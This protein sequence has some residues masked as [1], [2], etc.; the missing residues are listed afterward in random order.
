M[1]EAAAATQDLARDL[2]DILQAID[3]KASVDTLLPRFPRLSADDFGKALAALVDRKLICEAGGDAAGLGEAS[4]PSNLRSP[5]TLLKAQELR[6]KIR[7]K[8][9]NELQPKGNQTER[10]A[11]EAAERLRAEIEAEVRQ[12][13]EAEARRVAE[14]QARKKAAEQARKD[15]EE[16]IRQEATEKIRQEMA[17]RAQKE[18][19]ARVRQ[20]AEERARQEAE[21]RIRQEA[22]ERARQEAQQ[23]ARQEAEERARQEAAEQ[24]RQQAAERARQEAEVAARR[25]AEEQARRHAEEEAGREA[26]ARTRYEAEVRARQAEEERVWRETEDKMRREAAEASARL[27]KGKAASKEYKAGLGVMA[28]WGKMIALGVIALL[29]AGLAA[30]HLVSFDGKIPPLEKA[31]AAQFQ[32]PVKIASLRLSLL[33]KPMLR[34]EGVAIGGEGQIKIP[35][36]NAIG[37]VGNLFGQAKSFTALELDSPVASEEALGWILFGKPQ[38]ADIVFGQVRVIGGTLATKHLTLS[39]FDATIRPGGDAGWSTMAIESQD[40]NMVIELT[41]KGDSVQIEFKAKTFK[42]PFGSTLGLDEVVASGTA[43]RSAL[44]IKEFKGFAYGGTLGG[45]ATLTWGPTW[46][47]NGDMNAKQVDTARLLPGLMDSARLAGA[48]NYALQASEPAKLFAA[49]RLE[50]NFVIPRGTLLGVDMGRMLQG[51]DMRGETKFSE[52]IGSFVHERG[53]TQLRALRLSQGS[54]SAS[55][56]A[57]V[58]ADGNVRGRFA[59]ELKLTTEQRRASLGAAG[60]VKKIEWQRQ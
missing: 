37:G 47:L 6:A 34:L 59:V 23:R 3:G 30:M 50:G 29:A 10:E 21:E 40:K 49:P 48:A 55:G 56:A 8:R 31:L 13:L 54:M 36:V 7:A 25:A 1:A 5:E 60:T 38:A 20:E 14:E 4:G 45:N 18:A 58:D 53:A 19:E 32:Q 42:M 24:V 57:D 16:R 35:K 46:T 15:A 22:A 33:P 41:A 28:A 26:E 44:S 17:A 39:P 52:L 27:A 51:G 12:E 9:E 43:R 2:R 11:R